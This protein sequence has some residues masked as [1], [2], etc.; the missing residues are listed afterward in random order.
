MKLF[1]E[2]DYYFCDHCKSY[3]FPEPN[4]EGLRVLGKNPEGTHCPRCDVVMNLATIADFFQGY[5]CPE[6]LG[7]LFNRTTFREAIDFQRSRTK[8]P[9]EPYS[10]F[11]PTELKRI[12]IC[13]VCEQKMATFQYN[14]PGNIVIDTCHACDLIWLDFGELK[15]VVNAPGR[16][17]GVPRKLPKKEANSPEDKDREDRSVIEQA[18][19]QLA[20]RLF[21]SD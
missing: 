13:P 18:L 7:L 21:K 10:N 11:D 12:T 16:D 5:H 3:H 2:R 15:K 20:S 19:Q 6:C 1:R 17:R 4:Q 14:G 9:P 8:S